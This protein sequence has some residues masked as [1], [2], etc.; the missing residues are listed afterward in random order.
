[1]IADHKKEALLLLAPLTTN[2]ILFS[3]TCLVL[4]YRWPSC[5][6]WLLRISHEAPSRSC[7]SLALKK[8]AWPNKQC[9]YC[10]SG[11]IGNQ[12]RGWGIFLAHTFCFAVLPSTTSSLLNTCQHGTCCQSSKTMRCFSTEA[13]VQKPWKSI[14]KYERKA[15]KMMVW[16]EQWC[17]S[18]EA[19]IKMLS[20]SVRRARSI[21]EFVYQQ[22]RGGIVNNN[23]GLDL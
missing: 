1:M 5:C 19:E 10:L 7:K 9:S 21:Q 15:E 8:Q 22:Y 14:R 4:V 16:A 17:C 11:L 23:D 20:C 18:L 3:P 13:G 2:C 12:E 6:L